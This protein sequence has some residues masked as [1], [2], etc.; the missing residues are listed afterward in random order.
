MR[1]PTRADKQRALLEAQL[2]SGEIAPEEYEARL[3]R[4]GLELRRAIERAAEPVAVTDAVR[5]AERAIVL[6]DPG[7]GKT[8]LLRYLAL[9]HAEALLAG[10]AHHPEIGEPRVPVYV[11]VGSYSRSPLRE[12][13]LRAFIPAYLSQSLQCP[14]DRL[15]QYLDVQLRAGR[16]VVLLDGLDEVATAAERRAVV[17]DVDHFVLAYEPR[18]NR[19]VCTSRLRL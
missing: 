14:V 4:L 12:A 3:D 1:W 9:R 15:D 17:A 19:V 18:G 13:G 6:G 10:A 2:R 11:R 7:A 8:T 16:C 5:D